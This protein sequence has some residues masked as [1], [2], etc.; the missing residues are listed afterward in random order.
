[1]Q[2]S[3]EVHVLNPSPQTTN[4]YTIMEKDS[5]QTAYSI[6]EDNESDD[7]SA[8]DEPVEALLSDLAENLKFSIPS[9]VLFFL[10]SLCYVM[11]SIYDCLW[12]KHNPNYYNPNY[13]SY[14][15]DQNEETS[16]EDYYDYGTFK[17]NAYSI[18]SISGALFFVL[19][20]MTDLYQC[21]CNTQDSQIN[22]CRAFSTASSANGVRDILGNYIS[23]IL[24]G[25]GALTDAVSMSLSTQHQAVAGII[26]SHIYFL[27][28]IPALSN[29]MNSCP[30]S[31]APPG[32]R[33]SMIGDL[34]FF[35]GSLID[36]LISYINDPKLIQVNRNW[37]YGTSFL[38]S[39]LWLIDAILYLVG[40]YWVHRYHV[41]SQGERDENEDG[42][43]S[44][45]LLRSSRRIGWS[46]SLPP[47]DEDC[48][49]TLVHRDMDHSPPRW[50]PRGR[51]I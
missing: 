19:N 6:E 23:A 7:E 18:T 32:I 15:Y 20:A 30:F 47:E 35:I 26:S 13:Y 48:S 5:L 39:S 28:S 2:Y 3:F 44:S 21:R 38:S 34:L 31:S 4:E 29:V 8:F 16:V 22:L 49:N 43:N 41:N 14:S 40:D 12:L 45:V 42:E 25:S 50:I 36:V 11:I 51:I 10:G 17:I 46:S 33:F 24:F 37:I 9:N 27:S 1:V